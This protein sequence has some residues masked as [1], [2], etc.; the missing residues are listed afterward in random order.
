MI[1][2]RTYRRKAA[3]DC[4]RTNGS[5]N[6][7]GSA[8]LFVFAAL[9]VFLIVAGCSPASEGQAPGEENTAP[10]NN[11]NTSD[12]T[13]PVDKTNPADK[14]DGGSATADGAEEAARILARAQ[15]ATAAVSGFNLAMSLQQ[16]LVTGEDTSKLSMTNTG[17]ME[18]KPLAM[19]QTTKTDLDG[20]ASTIVS[21]LTPDGYYM[22]DLT[23]KEW[24]QM[25]PSEIPKIKETLSDFQ[26]APS[27]E[28]AK[29]AKYADH[30][31]VKENE[32]DGKT[33]VVY[34]G[35]G[36]DSDAKALTMELLRSTLGT[37]QMEQQVK[38]SINVKSL[39]YSLTF[40]R[41]TGYPLQLKAEGDVTVEYEPGKPSKL[42]QTFVLTYSGWNEKAAVTVPKE[43]RDAP[44]V[45]PPSEELLDE[46]T[47]GLP[48]S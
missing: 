42:H 48:A 35:D 28:L 39:A 32:D 8:V 21:Y 12:S 45:I 41:A 17:H 7:R 43:G 29:I 13:K 20:E 31:S 3:S 9:M 44:S 25:D 23:N 27:A 15:Q 5:T 18:L 40:D 19:K 10:M 26:T 47:E 4:P 16:V 2:N 33:T 37:D 36:I 30:F 11:P 38:D 6:A 1:G 24:S 46:L 34:D 14:K 22:H